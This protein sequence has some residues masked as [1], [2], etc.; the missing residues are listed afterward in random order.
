MNADSDPRESPRDAFD[1]LN[2]ALH[3]RRGKDIPYD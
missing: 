1:P 2:C 3:C